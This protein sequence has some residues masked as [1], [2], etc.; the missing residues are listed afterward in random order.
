MPTMRTISRLIL[1]ESSASSPP[2]WLS[3]VTGKATAETQPRRRSVLF[4]KVV[5]AIS[6]ASIADIFNKWVDQGNEVTRYDIRDLSIHFRSRK[7][8]QAALQIYDWMESIKLKI[9]NTD[10]AIRIS[11]LWKVEGLASAERYFNSLQESE[12]TIKTYGAL[13]NCYCNDKVLDKALQIFEKMKVLNYLSTL[14]YNNVMALYLSMEQPGK[15]V[16]LVQE[17]EENNIALDPYT[18]NLLINS[19]GAMKNFDAVEGVLEKMKINNVEC[20][21]FTYGNLATIYFNSGLHEKANDYLET[22]EKMKLQ[23][24]KDGFEACHTLIRLH[25]EMNNLSGVNRAWEAIK[26]AF[27]KPK[28]L[29]YLI[30]LLALSKLGDQENLEKLFEEWEKGCSEYDFRLPNVLL[31]YYLSRDMI[32]KAT[33]LYESMLKSRSG[34]NLKSLDL[35]AT[36]SMKNRQIDLA[37]EYLE[38]GLDKARKLNHEWF[39]TDETTKLFF[40]YF[41]ENNDAGR[42]EKFVQSMKKANRLDSALLNK[43]AKDAES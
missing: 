22:M 7:N 15:V 24:K 5:R 27:P 6:D 31:G 33:S 28:N 18:Y 14:N 12:K 37:L 4:N 13:L 43:K 19:Y 25:S 41:E 26:S 32:D 16:D 30:M 20:C 34:Y 1:R 3:T 17:M 8:F 23:P 29:D 38:M 2:R 42:Y 21:L 35:F 40:D 36:L 10:Q 39:P 9:Q 11:L